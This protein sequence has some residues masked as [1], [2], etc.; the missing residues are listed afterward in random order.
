MGMGRRKR[1]RQQEMWVATA[2]LPDVPRHV[3]YEKLN[4]LLDEHDFDTFV[5]DLC[6][7]SYAANGTL[8]DCREWELVDSHHLRKDLWQPSK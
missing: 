1:E 3:F 7:P 5:E 4:Q 2:S 8:A 6:E